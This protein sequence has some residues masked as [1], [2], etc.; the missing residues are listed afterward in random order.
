MILLE[1]GTH[2]NFIEIPASS[3]QVPESEVGG[4]GLEGGIE[5][6]GVVGDGS[7]GLHTVPPSPTQVCNH[8]VYNHTRLP[9]TF[10]DSR[11]LKSIYVLLLSTIHVT[12]LP[13]LHPC[14][15]LSRTRP[16]TPAPTLGS[17]VVMQVRVGAVRRRVRRRSRRPRPKRNP[18]STQ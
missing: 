11:K 4:F 3:P 2:V 16:S 12:S 9:A 13:N 7:E 17:Q 8:E 10:N 15:I 1:D 6:E 5:G 14:C 18:H